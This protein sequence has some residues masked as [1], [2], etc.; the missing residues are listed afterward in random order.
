MEWQR[1]TMSG[2]LK[3][4]STYISKCSAHLLFH[5]RFVEP[6]TRTLIEMASNLKVSNEKIAQ[7]FHNNNFAAAQNLKFKALL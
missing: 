6:T 7:I 1:L 2:P 3:S 4:T 5:I